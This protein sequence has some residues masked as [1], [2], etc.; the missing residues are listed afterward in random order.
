ML[1]DLCER[2]CDAGRVL[3]GGGGSWTTGEV[4]ER[5]RFALVAGGGEDDDV[6]SD[7][8]SVLCGAIFVDL[9]RAAPGSALNFLDL[10]VFQNEPLGTVLT[11]RARGVES[12]HQYERN[13]KQCFDHICVE[14]E[15]RIFRSGTE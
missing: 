15:N 8:A 14:I 6:Q 3:R 9:E 7:L 13:E 10:A 2:T 11:N 1:T 4:D 5:I 12:Q